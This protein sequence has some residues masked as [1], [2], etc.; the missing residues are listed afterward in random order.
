MPRCLSGPSSTALCIINSVLGLLTIHWTL[1]ALNG[2]GPYIP[3]MSALIL[4]DKLVRD[5]TSLR[6]ALPCLGLFDL[7]Y[8]DR[9]A[10]PEGITHATEVIHG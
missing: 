8:F 6:G 4:A 7:T 3:T 9:A 10:A 2:I 1:T 5:T